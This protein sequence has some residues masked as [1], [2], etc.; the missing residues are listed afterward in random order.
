MRL[1]QKSLSRVTLESMLRK[2]RT[3]LESF[4]KESGITTYDVLISRCSSIG[5]VPPEESEFLD[6]MGNP[7]THEFT[8]PTEG[9]VVLNPIED[10]STEAAEDQLDDQ[11]DAEINQQI[12][13]AETKK[14][15]KKT[16][17]S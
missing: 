4:L 11:K 6:A 3:T 8:M 5:V 13:V 9:I 15:K 1:H 10:T 7:V 12:D 14:K 2:K 17:D 16:S